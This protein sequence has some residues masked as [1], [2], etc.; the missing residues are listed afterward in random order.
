MA[1]VSSELIEKNAVA[2]ISMC[3]ALWYINETRQANQAALAY[4]DDQANN[5]NA[6][7]V[8]QFE[9]VGRVLPNFG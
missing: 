4:Y 8:I 5:S 2:W 7:T 9:S 1:S 6:E 3:V